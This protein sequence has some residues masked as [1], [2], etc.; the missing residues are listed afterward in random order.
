MPNYGKAKPTT[1]APFGI[2]I[3]E[4][5]K[6]IENTLS[7]SERNANSVV[8]YRKED[9]LVLSRQGDDYLTSVRCISARINEQIS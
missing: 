8:F 6:A 9:L 2:G 4:A 7:V 5:C 3:R 1:R